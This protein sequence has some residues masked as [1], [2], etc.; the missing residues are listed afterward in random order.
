[1]TDEKITSIAQ[2]VDRLGGKPAVADFLGVS[3]NAV[4][5]WIADEFIPKGWHLELWFK[6]MELGL[7]VP[8]QLFGFPPG[9]EVPPPPPWM[10]GRAA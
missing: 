4:S 8:P 1:M 3:T 9:F 5:N 6:G 10:C 2:F 7:R